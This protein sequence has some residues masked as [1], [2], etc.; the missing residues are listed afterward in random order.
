MEQLRPPLTLIVLSLF[1]F[2]GLVLWIQQVNSGNYLIGAVILAAGLSLERFT[3]Y[4]TMIRPIARDERI[5]LYTQRFTIQGVR[6]TLIW[7]A[8]LWI[9]LNLGAIR[10]I[11]ALVFL[12]VTMLLEHSVDVAEHN[13][14]PRLSYLNHPKVLLLT[15]IEAIGAT[16]WLYLLHQG[17]DTTALGVLFV[18]FIAEHIFQGQMVEI[19]PAAAQPA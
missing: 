11:A 1:E 15:A 9:A 16:A 12:F 10:Y 6:E 3:V 5:G 17:Q 2:L 4:V 7:V 13:G 19:K 18:A 8:W 14:V